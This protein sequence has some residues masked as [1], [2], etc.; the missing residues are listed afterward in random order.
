[1]HYYGKEKKKHQYKVAASWLFFFLVGSWRVYVHARG[2]HA[3]SV[4]K[5][6]LFADK[7]DNHVVYSKLT[8]VINYRIYML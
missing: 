4:E 7:K 2:L 6:K 1:M 5:K 8:Q 3:H